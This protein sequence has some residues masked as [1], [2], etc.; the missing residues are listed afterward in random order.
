MA[1]NPEHPKDN[2]GNELRPGALYCCFVDDI[3][4]S[5]VWYAADGNFYDANYDDTE[6]ELV[7][8]EFDYLVRQDAP[9][10][11]NYL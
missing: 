11:A 5:L 9:I 6:G 3:D 1:T 2:E 8:P 4:G 10:N 7:Y